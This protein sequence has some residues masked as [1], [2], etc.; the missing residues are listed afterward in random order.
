VAT[1]SVS[2]RVVR[3]P[4]VGVGPALRVKG[5]LLAQMNALKLAGTQI[6]VTNSDPGLNLSDPPFTQFECNMVSANDTTLIAFFPGWAALLGVS[7]LDTEV[8]TWTS[9]H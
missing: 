9:G 3:I 4:N 5:E 7:L 2:R 1:T 8:S 6:F